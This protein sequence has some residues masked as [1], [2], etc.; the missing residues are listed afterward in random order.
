MNQVY[1]KLLAEAYFQ[2]DKAMQAFY[3][4]VKAG[5][6]PGFPRFRPRHAFFTLCYPARFLLAK[7]AGN[8]R[9]IEH[10]R[11]V[12]PTSGKSKNKGFLIPQLN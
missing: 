11:I 5:E 8:A 12:L 7:R 10:N 2:I 9:Q 6:T 3:R 4:R 1:G